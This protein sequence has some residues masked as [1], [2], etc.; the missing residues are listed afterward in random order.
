MKYNVKYK[1][2][3]DKNDNIVDIDTVTKENKQEEYYSIGTHTPMEAALGE[4]NQHY[5]RAKRGY[6]LNPETELHDYTKRMLK[7]R[8]DTED[9]FCIKYNRLDCCSHGKSCIFYE[10]MEGGC[11]C[12][13]S[14]SHEYDL[15]R[16]YDTATI[17]AGCG[18]FV[19]DVLLT[20]STHPN[21][22]PVFL[23]VAVTH[24]CSQEKIDS[25][26]KIVELFVVS[27]EDAFC[28]LEQSAPY[29]Y[30]GKLPKIKF[31]NFDDK[32]ILTGCPHFAKE[33]K[34]AKQPYVLR[35][36]YI[37]TKFYCIPQQITATPLKAYYDNTEIGMLFASNLFGKPFVF[38]KAISLD[39]SRFV[40][41]G[42]DIYG[43]VEPWIVYGVTWNGIEYYHTVSAYLDYNSALKEFTT[44]Q[45]KEWHGGE[46]LSDFC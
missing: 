5:F 9:K 36:S 44:L 41:M 3:F 11:G 4:K 30:D 8:F 12:L 19:A 23:E 22:K 32:T 46:T 21:R 2:V 16:L 7:Y 25:K 1:K 38:D 40:M 35:D 34:Y 29:D 18:D 43:A 13:G 26:N 39:R 42:K 28:K 33:K 45:G 37:R 15:K 31:H 17:E 20:S 6:V 10:E 24:P 14:R 27:E